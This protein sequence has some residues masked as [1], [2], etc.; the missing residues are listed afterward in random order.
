MKALGE[1]L[2]GVVLAVLGGVIFLQNV[3]V[4]G[5]Y[6][7]FYGF[8]SGGRFHM[9]TS[10]MGMLVVLMCVFFFLMLV[11]PN[12]ITKGLMFL[13]FLCFVVTMILSLNFG[14]KHMN[15]FVLFSILALFV[16]GLAF[17]FKAVLGLENAEK[18][19][20]IKKEDKDK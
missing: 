17:I 4:S 18:E 5:F 9:G 14:F 20:G 3:T 7:G 19:A 10:S 12:P 6:A 8:T 16:A 13:S 15:A 1:F 2:I 11:K